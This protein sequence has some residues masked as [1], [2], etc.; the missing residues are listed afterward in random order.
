VWRLQHLEKSWHRLGAGRTVPPLRDEAG[1]G[2][3]APHGAR[4]YPAA[5]LS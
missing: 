2:R 1:G 4:Q 5:H 3:G